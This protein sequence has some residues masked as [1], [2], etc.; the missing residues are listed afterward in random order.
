[1]ENGEFG[2]KLEVGFKYNLKMVCIGG[3]LVF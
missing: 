1:M 3:F 2:L